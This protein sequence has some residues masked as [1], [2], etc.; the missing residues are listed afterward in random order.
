MRQLQN[1]ALWKFPHSF[2]SQKVENRDPNGGRERQGGE[3]I[4]T[5]GRKERKRR[6]EREGEKARQ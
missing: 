1:Y 6:I 5:E 4:E 3:K 2:N